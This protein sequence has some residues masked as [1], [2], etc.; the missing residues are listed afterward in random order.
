MSEI[1]YEGL[2]SHK[3]VIQEQSYEEYWKSTLALTDFFGD[4]FI[5][6][7]RLMIE[8]IDKYG[9]A[10][11]SPQELMDNMASLRKKFNRDESFSKELENT[12][13]KIYPNMS[14]DGASTRKQL[15]TFIKLGFIKPF[16]RGYVPAAKK[17][18]DLKTTKEERKRLFSDTVYQYASFNSS[19]TKDDT[20][21]NQIKFLVKTLLNKSDKQLSMGEFIGVMQMNPGEFA[22]GYADERTLRAKTNY[23][24]HINFFERKY[25]QVA[26]LRSILKSMDLFEVLELD[27]KIKTNKGLRREFRICLAQDAADLIPVRGD[28]KRDSYRFGLMKK[29][30][31]EETKRIYGKPVSWFSKKESKG[32]VVSHIYASADALKDWDLDAA[33]D[34][35]NALY[36]LPGNEDQYF[37][38]YEMTFDD[39]G[40]PS[41]LESVSE[42]F[43]HEAISQHYHLD[44]EVLTSERLHYLKLYHRVKFEENRDIHQSEVT[45]A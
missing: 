18:V 15:N 30:V 16:L 23:A 39:D 9:L 10:D 21:N 20:Q 45:K 3:K 25:N 14:D 42:S 24:Q 7:L 19:Q 28:T 26:H 17:F 35:N 8:H 44:K 34:P 22:K 33:Y 41:F 6:T 37:D 11:K 32:M 27:K 13:R 43:V 36:L 31:I 40:C 12:V 29:A 5:T 1:S 4:Q 38:K 2:N